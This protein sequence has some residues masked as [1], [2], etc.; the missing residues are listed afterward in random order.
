MFPVSKSNTQLVAR[1]IYNPV[2]HKVKFEDFLK[3]YHNGKN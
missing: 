2:T 1:C 3:Y